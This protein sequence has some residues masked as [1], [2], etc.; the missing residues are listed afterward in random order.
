MVIKKKIQPV[1]DRLRWG[2]GTLTYT[3]DKSKKY[4]HI[5]YLYKAE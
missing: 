3:V 1:D 4:T 5:L 2:S